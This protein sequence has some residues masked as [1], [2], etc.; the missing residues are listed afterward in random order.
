[1]KK[2]VKLILHITSF[3]TFFNVK[4]LFD[5]TCKFWEEREVGI[6]KATDLPIIYTKY[7]EPEPI[8]KDY[9]CIHWA[10]W[11]TAGLA[12]I[13]LNWVMSLIPLDTAHSDENLMWSASFHFTEIKSNT[14]PIFT[15]FLKLWLLHMGDKTDIKSNKMIFA[16]YTICS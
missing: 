10:S 7:T 4:N 9:S 12:P 5:N 16:L 2:I 1:M 13:Q 14:A 8:S 11:R 3:I 6:V 15:R